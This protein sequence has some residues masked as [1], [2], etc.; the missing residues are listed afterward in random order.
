MSLTIEPAAPTAGRDRTGSRRHVWPCRHC[1]MVEDYRLNREAQLQLAEGVFGQDEDFRVNTFK[2]WLQTFE[3]DSQR[4]HH[5][6]HNPDPHAGDGHHAGRLDEDSAG[7]DD[8]D[9]WTEQLSAHGRATGLAT[10]PAMRATSGTG[11]DDVTDR[12]TSAEP[13][14]AQHTSGAVMST[15]EQMTPAAAVERLIELGHDRAEARGLVDSYLVDATDNHGV[16]AGGWMVDGYDLADMRASAYGCVGTNEDESLPAARERAAEAARVWAEEVDRLPRD[17]SEP[18]GAGHPDSI[19]YVERCAQTWA[20]RAAGTT[21]PADTDTERAV[22]QHVGELGAG[23]HDAGADDHHADDGRGDEDGVG[24]RDAG[25]EVVGL[26]CPECEEDVTEQVPTTLVPYEAHGTEGPAYSHLDGEPLC[27]VVGP[28]GYQPADPMELHGSAA[29][30]RAPQSVSETLTPEVEGGPVRTDGA[31]EGPDLP[32][33]GP[34]LP[35]PAAGPLDAIAA[36][37]RVAAAHDAVTRTGTGGAPGSRQTGVAS[38][39]DRRAQLATWAH[40]DTSDDHADGAGR[41]ME[42][43]R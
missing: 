31:D 5:E 11:E 19:A 42:Q 21:T 20:A 37:Q 22:G 36:E 1:A 12:I 17:G 34:R 14:A 7:R 13:G 10:G 18:Y 16:P 8:A 15:H 4:E 30:Q 23:E 41:G 6:H 38:E 43:Q 32:E 27:P 25:P 3:W 9:L 24:G 35:A 26:V 39:Q 29:V 2:Q 40:H 28:R 33:N